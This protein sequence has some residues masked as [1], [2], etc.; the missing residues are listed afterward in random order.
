MH[1]RPLSSQLNDSIEPDLL[2]FLR[3][4]LNTLL[5]WELA[6]YFYENPQTADIADNLARYFGRDL[7]NIEEEL[8]QL[9][10]AGVLR[11]EPAQDVLVY[12]LTEDADTLALL[13]QF[14]AASRDREFKMRAIYLV[15]QAKR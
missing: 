3:A 14:V 4:R 6:H 9:A 13:G 10:R 7:H 5:K 12:S 2:A 1:T 15:L 8:A 11:A